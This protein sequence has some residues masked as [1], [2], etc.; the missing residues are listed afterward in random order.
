[1]PPSASLGTQMRA[2][3]DEAAAIYETKPITLPL[4]ACHPAPPN[5]T[6]STVGGNYVCEQIYTIAPPVE[7]KLQIDICPITSQ[8]IQFCQ[9]NILNEGPITT[10]AAGMPLSYRKILSSLW[11]FKYTINAPLINNKSLNDT[12]FGTLATAILSATGQS[13]V[14]ISVVDDKFKFQAFGPKTSLVR[15]ALRL[16]LDAKSTNT[17]LLAPLV[18]P[19]V[20]TDDK[21]YWA[22]I[23]FT[24]EIWNQFELKVQNEPNLSRTNMTTHDH[25]HRPN[26]LPNSNSWRSREPN[27]TIQRNQTNTSIDTHSHSE[28]GQRAHVTRKYHQDREQGN[29]HSDGQQQPSLA[30]HSCLARQTAPSTYTHPPKQAPTPLG[31]VRG[32]TSPAPRRSTPP[33]GSTKLGNILNL[34]R[35]YK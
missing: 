34:T 23:H 27:P 1:M 13:L 21:N 25:R 31:G 26:S 12:S 22:P 30:R 15:L 6:A 19:D 20:P 16:S 28:M 11:G 33:N 32:K 24:G 17:F 18:D 35:A 14:T 5:L 10:I 3:Q 7:H 4:E 29:S 8:G 9:N 2:I